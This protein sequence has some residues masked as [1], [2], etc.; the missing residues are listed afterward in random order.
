MTL[1]NLKNICKFRNVE[2]S[3]SCLWFE[4]WIV[5]R[6]KIKSFGKKESIEVRCE[7]SN[8]ICKCSNELETELDNEI[9]NIKKNKIEQKIREL[10]QDFY[11]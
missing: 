5:G 6:I 7:N 11:G 9:K 1:E 3:W 10:E 4:R 2:I 8:L